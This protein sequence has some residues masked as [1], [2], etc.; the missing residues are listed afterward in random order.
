MSQ[1]ESNLV[2]LRDILEHL[3]AAQQ[4]L[5]WCDDPE[6]TRLVTEQ[7]LRD[8]ERCRRLCETMHRRGAALQGAV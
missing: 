7:M 3:S 4:R 5:E 2:W 6:T 1:R 8:L